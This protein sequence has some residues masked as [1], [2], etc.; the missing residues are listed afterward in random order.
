MKE[1]LLRLGKSILGSIKSPVG[2]TIVGGFAGSAA[3]YFFSRTKIAQDLEQ[4]QI[5]KKRL[6][7]RVSKLE[8]EKS[9]IS[10][11]N[12]RIVNRNDE[13]RD[14]LRQIG[15]EFILTKN[16]LSDCEHDTSAI[17]A[18]YAN[19]WCFWKSPIHRHQAIIPNSDNN[20]ETVS[21]L[22]K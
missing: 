19:S 15:R 8:I 16:R 14:E 3:T 13:L 20:S 12:A 1:K 6:E 11:L 2:L 22:A 18:S 4:A 5:D 9:D 21:K 17:M 7:E 10:S